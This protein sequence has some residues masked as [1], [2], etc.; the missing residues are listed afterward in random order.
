MKI[1]PN[2]P[3]YPIVLAP[4]TEQHY[5]IGIPIRLEIAARVMAGFAANSESK[6]WTAEE[7]AADALEWADTLIAKVNE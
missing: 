5:T 7:M 3:A 2:D 6:G 4:H 1:N